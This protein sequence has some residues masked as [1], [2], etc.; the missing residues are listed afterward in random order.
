MMQLISKPQVGFS[1]LG[2]SVPPRRQDS[3]YEKVDSTMQNKPPYILYKEI[4]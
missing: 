2:L 1:A 3:V 4:G